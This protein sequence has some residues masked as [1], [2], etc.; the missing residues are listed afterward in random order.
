MDCF[1]DVF[2]VQTMH[3]KNYIIFVF[4]QPLIFRIEGQ[5]FCLYKILINGLHL[6]LQSI[7]VNG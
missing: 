2:S 1:F 7:A 4:R 6:A 5:P 3:V